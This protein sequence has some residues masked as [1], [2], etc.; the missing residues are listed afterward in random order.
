MTNA[1]AARLAARV[2]D[3]DTYGDPLCRRCRGD[4]S[5]QVEGTEAARNRGFARCDC[6]DRVEEAMDRTIGLRRAWPE[7]TPP[8]APPPERPPGTDP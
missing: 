2:V 5:V 8:A 3:A 7:P 6:V 4:G 1:F